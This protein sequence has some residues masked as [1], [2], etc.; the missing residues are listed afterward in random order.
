M[1]QNYHEFAF[2]KNV[3]DVILCGLHHLQ[4]FPE[5]DL[6]FSFIIIIMSQ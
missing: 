1:I 4:A 2:R 3:I 5:S 6:K